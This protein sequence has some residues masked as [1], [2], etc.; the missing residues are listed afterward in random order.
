[1]K[2]L[3][4]AVLV[5]LTALIL[6]APKF[7]GSA[8]ENERDLLLTEFNKTDGINIT[9]K[10]YNNSWFGAEVSSELTINLE[11]EGLAELT[12]QL[13]E[14]LSFGP[15][16]ITEQGFL[17]GL[18]YSELSFKLASADV[19]SDVIALINEK[20]HLGALLDFDN[21][22]TSFINTDKFSYEEEGSSLVSLPASAKFTLI[23]NKR[24]S[25]D[26]YWGG[27]E[28]DELGERLAIGKVVMSTKQEVVSGDYLQGTA[29]LTGEAK[30]NVEKV[31]VHIQDEHIFSLNHTELT[32][33]VS[34]DNDLLALNVKYHAKDISASGQYFEKPNLEIEL[35]KV[36]FNALQELNNVLSDL[37]SDTTTD[38]SEEVLQVLTNVAE[39][40]LAKDPT[41]KVTDLSVVSEEGKVET[42]MNFAINK[43]LVDT[44]NLNSMSLVMAL[45]ADAK[46]K[47]PIAF[48]TKFG[49][50]PMV[51]G[52]VQQ[53]YLN[54]QESDISFDAKYK[55][56]ELTLNGKPLQL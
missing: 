13:E 38:N 41:L 43:D 26:F 16:L 2:K 46:G 51:D 20:I 49:V 12:L 47:A 48:L 55:Q 1:M 50:A 19:D 6:I 14:D 40:V 9:T 54:K 23:D 34:V 31:N 42:A 37:S 30:F 44:K 4:I 45:E 56:G 35:A 52:F 11:D 21:N 33:E 18:G 36:D 3:F 24:L 25:G 53:G 7:I 17:I 39:K 8:V 5:I 27:L 22:I 32:S 28:L 29:I 15:L 10:K